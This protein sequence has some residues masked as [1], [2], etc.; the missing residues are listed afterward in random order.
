MLKI[1]RVLCLVEPLWH[2][3]HG[4]LT[5]LQCQG[6][7]I[8]I[9]CLLPCNVKDTGFI[10]PRKP[11]PFL[12]LRLWK[13]Y[14]HFRCCRK[15]VVKQVTL[16]LYMYI[17]PSPSPVPS[18]QPL[19]LNVRAYTGRLWSEIN[20]IQSPVMESHNRTV[21]SNDALEIDV[22]LA[23]MHLTQ[24]NVTLTWLWYRCPQPRTGTMQYQWQN[25]RGLSKWQHNPTRTGLILNPEN[26]RKTDR[27]R[28]ICE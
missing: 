8:D 3:Y 27:L 7:P 1:Q 26:D 5:I 21:Q 11:T 13:L 9:A 28:S 15:I 4:D 18:Q 6:D 23:L 24:S 17:H 25:D 22:N 20:F 14:A 12:C 10:R 19:G 2:G 16:T